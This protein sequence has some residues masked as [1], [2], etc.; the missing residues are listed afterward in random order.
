MKVIKTSALFALLLALGACGG[1]GSGSGGT[2]NG[3]T[4]GSV[5]GSTPSSA[6]APA[7]NSSPPPTPSPTP[8]PSVP[9]AP[10][11]SAV[12]GDI[13]NAAGRIDPSAYVA[14][15]AKLSTDEGIAYRYGAAAGAV[16]PPPTWHKRADNPKP[17]CIPEGGD[18][19]VGNVN[20]D[21]GDYFS[22]SGNVLFVADNP[23]ARVGVS[24]FKLLI[25]SYNTLSQRPEAT[26]LDDDQ[27]VRAGTRA[28]VA[29]SRCYGRPGWCLVSIVAYQDGKLVTGNGGNTGRNYATTQLAANKIPT[30]IAVTNS[31]EFALV[32][33]WDTAALKGQIAVVALAGMCN[34]CTPSQPGTGNYWG[35]WSAAYPGLPNLGNTA[36]MKVLGYVDLPESM[37]APTEITATTGWDPW[38]N[39]MRD[40]GG[41]QTSANALPLSNET[42]RQSFISPQGTNGVFDNTRTYAKGGIA[43]VV[44]KSEKRAAFVD[45]KPLFDYYKSMYFGARADFDK[46][47]SVGTADNQWPYAFSQLPDGVKPRVVQTLD[48]GTKPTAVKATL[49]GNNLRAWIATQEGN[50]SLYNIDGYGNG[51]GTSSF[52]RVGYIPVGA[53]PVSISYSRGDGQKSNDTALVLSR[54]DKAVRWIDFSSDR[55]GGTVR[56][57][58]L[59]DSRLVDPVGIEDNEYHGT[60]APVV[61][62]ADYGGKMLRNYRYG[63]VIF[64]SNQGSGMACQPPAGCGLG[65]A[66]LPAS[67]YPFEY[68]GDQAIQGKAFLVTGGNIP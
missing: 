32:T 23:A 41:N 13:V 25:Q 65:P 9:V 53:N 18:W 43:V 12:S 52:A 28:P 39:V 7:A 33:V 16:N 54:G 20:C 60:E 68:G 8:S 35:E 26:S 67:Q 21:P 2:A 4:S 57:A 64:W 5:A 30:G 22:N 49:W 19:Q 63:P 45:L 42:N 51:T 1:G 48:L 37:R 31:N 36:F 46:T 59:T 34:G 10:S 62:V 11:G 55:N 47:A 17:S 24:D 58:V 6:E 61:S 50:V 56:P 44:S 29:A 40:A 27:A 38:A 14:M 15:A 66:N 3:Q